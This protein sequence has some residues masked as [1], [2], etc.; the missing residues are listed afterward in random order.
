MIKVSIL[1]PVYG[2]EA[3]I[4]RCA[5][6]LME[7]T[8]PN[9]EYIFVDDCSPDNSISILQ[10]VIDEYHR[11]DVTIIRHETNKGL[12]GARKT[13]LLAASGD[14]ILN[15]DSDDYLEKTAVSLLVEEIVKRQADVVKLSCFMEWCNTKK[16]YYGAWNEN[17]HQYTKL[18]LSAKTLPGVCLHIIRRTLYFE[19]H[20]FPTEGINLGEDFILTPR[21]CYYAN[22]IGHVDEPIY[23]YIQTNS[24][25]YTSS[26]NAKK[27][28]D[29]S[30]VA[31]TLYEFFKDKPDFLYA[32]NEGMWQKKVEMM[33]NCKLQ[34]YK[35]V[36]TLPTWLPVS[37]GSMRLEQRIAAPLVAKKLWYALW[38]YSITYNFVFRIVQKL[39]G[40]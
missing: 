28:E 40:R 35:L 26:F 7:Q 33:L 34:N 36:D 13:A 17:A 14:Y 10:S 15:V 23:H 29:L 5:R 9:I 12:G 6:S 25:S 18:L 24:S 2:V 16:A 8:Y 32:L 1:V 31:N 30:H 39:K 20:L 19:H 4:E 3:F 27:V 22:C 11:D 21:L 37:T 38:L